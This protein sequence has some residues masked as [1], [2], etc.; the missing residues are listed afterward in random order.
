MSKRGE[1]VSARAEP[2]LN[3]AVRCRRCEAR[4][5]SQ[6]YNTVCELDV[7][8]VRNVREHSRGETH[9]KGE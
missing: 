4:S 2:V 9:T 5:L 6:V 8:N 7:R 1:R 3:Y